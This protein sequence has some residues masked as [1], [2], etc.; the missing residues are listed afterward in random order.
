MEEHRFCPNCGSNEVEPD[1]RRTNVLGEMMFNQNKWLCNDCGY[2]GI[3]PTG[4]PPE[5]TEFDGEEEYPLVDSDAGRAYAKYF[6]YIFVPVMAF[7][8]GYLL[9]RGL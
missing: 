6:L 8:I 4:E 2:A 5:D 3:M 7:W 1:F 9:F